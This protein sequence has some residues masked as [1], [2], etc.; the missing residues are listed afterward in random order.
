LEW[1]CVSRGDSK[2]QTHKTL[3]SNSSAT[4]K[5]KERKK[6][7]KKRK[8]R[9]KERSFWLLIVVANIC[10][11]ATV[12]QKSCLVL[13]TQKRPGDDCRV[14]VLLSLMSRLLK[15]RMLLARVKSTSLDS[16]KDP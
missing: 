4:Q 2:V 8:K 1:R 13:Y 9:K 7:K 3:S 6:R 14:R 15:P 10:C 12:S 5:L 11:V 16:R